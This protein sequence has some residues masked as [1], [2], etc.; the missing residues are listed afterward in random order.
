M[1]DGLSLATEFVPGIGP[2]WRAFLAQKR[3]R[4]RGEPHPG[5]PA[6]SITDFD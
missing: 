3:A 2:M 1:K 6:F 4:Y 5:G